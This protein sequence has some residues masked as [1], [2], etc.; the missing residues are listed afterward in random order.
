MGCLKEG[1]R[2]ATFA[3]PV[4]SDPLD[5]SF[6]RPLDKV[7]RVLEEVQSSAIGIGDLRSEPMAQQQHL[8]CRVRL[9]M[10]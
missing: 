4:G 2:S 1:G 8:T 10:A 5:P 6:D 7:Q 3:I 9:A